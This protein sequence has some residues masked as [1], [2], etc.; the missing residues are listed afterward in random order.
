VIVDEAGEPQIADSSEGISFPSNDG[1][2]IHMD[3]TAIWGIMPEQAA[4][5]IR[6][7]GNVDAVEQK[8]VLPQIESICRNSGSLYSAVELLVGEDRQKFQ[9]QTSESFRSVLT[10]K[11]IT[12]LY[13]LVRHIYIPTEVR[14]PIQTAFIA[15]ELKLTREQEQATAIEEGNLREAERKVELEAEKIRADTDKQVAEKLAEGKKQVGETHAETVKLVA[16]IDKQTAG[17]EAQATIVLGEADAKAR[18]LLEEARAGRFLLAVAAFGTPEAY[19]SWI[20]ASGL[21]DDIELQLLYAGEGTLWTDLEDL[22]LRA[23]V[24]VE[25]KKGR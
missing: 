4:D 7:F 22:G 14:L 21:P 5:A 2:P 19:N 20:F 12:L 24:P 13:G 9:M 17:L 11:N 23:N 8:V 3:F 25:Q 6:T 15:D 16:A 1:F 10:E 18:Q